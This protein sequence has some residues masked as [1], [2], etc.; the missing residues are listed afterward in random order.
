MALSEYEQK[1]LSELEYSLFTQDPQ[2]GESLS[3]KRIYARS[4]RIVRWGVTGFV[5][6]SVCLLT[7]FTASF[8]LSLVGLALMFVS[9]VAVV[10]SVS[11]LKRVR[12]VPT[13]HPSVRI[14]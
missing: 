8:A 7:F 14:G 1:I 6:G 4:R 11:A 10:S 2:F 5:A 13:S 3:G 9:S 12:K